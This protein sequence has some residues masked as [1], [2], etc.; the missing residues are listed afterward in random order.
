MDDPEGGT[1]SPNNTV[2]A[3]P[4]Q[5]HLLKAVKDQDEVVDVSTMFKTNGCQVKPG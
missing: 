5:N 2:P 4:P 1:L 3:K